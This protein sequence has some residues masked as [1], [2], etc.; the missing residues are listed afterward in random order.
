MHDVFLLTSFLSLYETHSWRLEPQSL[1]SI[2]HKHL[3][4]WS[5]HHTKGTWIFLLMS[6]NM[7]RPNK[8]VNGLV[9]SDT[10]PNTTYLAG[11]YSQNAADQREGPAN[12][13]SIIRCFPLDQNKGTLFYLFFL[14]FFW[15]RKYKGTY[16]FPFCAWKYFVTK[17]PYNN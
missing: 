3:Y 7:L 16:T 1:H 8:N 12:Y 11:L 5:D 2:P 14:F 10:S 15:L 13:Q 17:L 6:I 9:E 4:F